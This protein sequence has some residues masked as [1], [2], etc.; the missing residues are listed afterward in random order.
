MLYTQTHCYVHTITPKRFHSSFCEIN[1]QLSACKPNFAKVVRTTWKIDRANYR[2]LIRS[3]YSSCVHKVL[4]VQKTPPG[5]A[6]L[7][8]ITCL[9]PVVTIC[10]A[11]LAFSNST[12]YPHSRIY[13][14]CVDLRKNSNYFRTQHWLAGFHKKG[15][16][17]ISRFS[18]R[19]IFDINKSA[20][21][22]SV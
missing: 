4:T 16:V 3:A 5:D 21:Q 10:T 14:F 13:V 2:L 11:S 20:F 22:F 17:S 18:S 1:F 15:R 8:A 9:S 6:K 19:C 12:F 7:Q